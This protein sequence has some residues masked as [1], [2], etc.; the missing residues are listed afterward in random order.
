MQILGLSAPQTYGPEILRTEP[1]RAVLKKPTG[2]SDTKH[3]ETCS[4][5]I[6]HLTAYSV[7][8]AYLNYLWSFCTLQ[9]LSFIP[10]G[11]YLIIP[12]VMVFADMMRS[13]AVPGN[14]PHTIVIAHLIVSL[15]APLDSEL[16]EGQIALRHISLGLS[17]V[18]GTWKAAQSTL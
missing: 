7:L 12:Y 17:T 14:L 18:S 2:D 10:R 1:S 4:P 16:R 9:S 3:W 8:I 6:L 11:L 15:L 13:S 5:S